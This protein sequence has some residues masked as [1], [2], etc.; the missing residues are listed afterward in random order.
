[1]KNSADVN[2]ASVTDADVWFSH[3]RPCRLDD[4]DA[5][6]QATLDIEMSLN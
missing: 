4:R 1:M 5:I 6:L 3:L 2:G